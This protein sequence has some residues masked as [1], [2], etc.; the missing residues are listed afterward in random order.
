MRVPHSTRMEPETKREG[1][2]PGLGTGVMLSSCHY[3]L[4]RNP[5]ESENFKVYLDLPAHL[6]G[7]FLNQET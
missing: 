6:G 1:G 3:A 7:K 4:V 2:K 5:N